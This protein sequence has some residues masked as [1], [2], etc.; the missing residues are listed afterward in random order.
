MWQH[1]DVLQELPLPSWVP[2]LHG[3]PA[4]VIPLVHLRPSHSVRAG[5]HIRSLQLP[6]HIVRPVQAEEVQARLPPIR[7]GDY[8]QRSGVQ[9][10]QEVHTNHVQ[11]VPTGQPVRPVQPET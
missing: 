6:V 4:N 2:H 5:A 9:G 1:P 3:Q 8:R 7:E 11:E 10:V